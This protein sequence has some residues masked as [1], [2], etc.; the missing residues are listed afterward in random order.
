MKF[1]EL[2]FKKSSVVPIACVLYRSVAELDLQKESRGRGQRQGQGS[3]GSD[4]GVSG[5]RAG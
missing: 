2:I 4:G 5:R 3:C 1:N